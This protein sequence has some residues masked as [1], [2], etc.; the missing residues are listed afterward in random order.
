MLDGTLVTKPVNHMVH[1]E[2]TATDLDMAVAH[3]PEGAVKLRQVLLGRRQ[4]AVAGHEHVL[5]PTKPGKSRGNENKRN[6][7]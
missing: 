6:E 5:H 2:A 4:T 7:T 3:G 1:V